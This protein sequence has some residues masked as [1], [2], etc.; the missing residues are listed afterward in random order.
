M[1][2]YLQGYTPNV[3]WNTLT[4]CILEQP[5]PTAALLAKVQVLLGRPAIVFDL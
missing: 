5:S 3:P 1:D 2:L 4:L